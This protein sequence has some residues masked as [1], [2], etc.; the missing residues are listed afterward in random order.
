MIWERILVSLDPSVC[1]LDVGRLERRLTDD[2]GIQDYAQRPDVHLVR[3]ACSAFKN[4]WRDVVW[5][6]A[7]GSLLLAVEIELGGQAKV[8]QF[9]LHLIVQEQVSEF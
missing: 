8:S 5:S 6:S 3:V 7:N 2:E 1:G 9:Y 4:F